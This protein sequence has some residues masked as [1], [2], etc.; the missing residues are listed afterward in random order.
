MGT[1]ITLE[2]VLSVSG[3]VDEPRPNKIRIEAA[4]PEGD[5][6]T[7][8]SDISDELSSIGELVGAL[9]ETCRN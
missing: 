3:G 4:W 1:Y 7:I 8:E 6:I 5:S 2:L 9:M